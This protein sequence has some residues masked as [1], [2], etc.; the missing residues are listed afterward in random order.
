MAD[1]SGQTLGRYHI[2]RKV[3]RGGMS[4]V[5][6][7]FDSEKQRTVAVKILASFLVDE[8]QFRS[9]FDR[10]IQL[11]QKLDHPNIV[12]IIDYGEHEDTPYIVMP[13][14]EATLQDRLKSS[15]MT[16]LEGAKLSE[17]ISASLEHAH[18]HGVVHRD[19]KPSNILLDD[20]G[21]A[22][23]SDFGFAHW[24]ESK[25]SLTG[26]ALIGT[27]AYMSPEQCIG[28]EI[29]ARSDQYSFA[30]VMYQIA[31]GRLPFEGETPLA[32]A[33]KQ[34][35]ED[36][37]SPKTVN[38]RLPDGVD[39][40]LVKALMKDPDRRFKS[41]AQF[42]ESFQSA[43]AVV[44]D[45]DKKHT[46][47]PMH[48]DLET[49]AMPPSQVGVLPLVSRIRSMRWPLAAGI[50]LILFAF[51]LGAAALMGYVRNGGG[52]AQQ[53]P[54]IDWEATISVLYAENAAAVGELGSDDAVQTAVVGTMQAMNAEDDEG[55]NGSQG[56]IMAIMNAFGSN[57]TPTS[58][59]LTATP[60]WF[61]FF[62]RTPTP[63]EDSSGPP[64]PTSTPGTTQEPSATPEPGATDTVPAPTNTPEPPPPTDPPPPTNPPP[65]TDPPPPTKKPKPTKRPSHTPRP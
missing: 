40:V 16:A 44:V 26:S 19:V 42:D 58:M 33:M 59:G 39:L 4:V 5:Y 30:V 14:F 17:Q 31:T 51:P 8:P 62:T 56:E 12:P 22:Y 32:V 15:P 18:Q 37:P 65:P 46:P 63:K 60:T 49:L 57:S 7:G 29:D 35:N 47:L 45:P 25:E 55:R 64:G 28:G 34:I 9:R 48:L 36:L 43:V 50:L 53:T 20:D 3:G 6:R 1:Y 23:L 2:L 54:T 21:K 52:D 11:L 10:E 41:V 61:V 24:H 38:P 13:F 27:P